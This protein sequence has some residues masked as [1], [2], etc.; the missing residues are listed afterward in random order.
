M[1]SVVFVHSFYVKALVLFPILLRLYQELISRGLKNK[2]R[3]LRPV[4]SRRLAFSIVLA[5][6]IS[7]IVDS[8]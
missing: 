8:P 3:L 6:G 2:A 1:S 4:I 5:G 7:I